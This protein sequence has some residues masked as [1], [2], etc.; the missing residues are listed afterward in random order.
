MPDLNGV[1]FRPGVLA[2]APD[3][4]G[5]EE[6]LYDQDEVEVDDEDEDLDDE[7]FFDDDEEELDDDDED[8]F[9][10]DDDEKDPSASQGAGGRG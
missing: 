6:E 2:V 9:D 10:D 7:D 8:F 4:G 3:G 1:A 5:D